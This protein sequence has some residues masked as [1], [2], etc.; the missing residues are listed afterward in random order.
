MA[1]DARTDGDESGGRSSVWTWLL[2]AL[3]FVA[4]VALG[5][6]VVAVGASGGDD[7][8]PDVSA[9]PTSE[10]DAGA[11][12]TSTAPSDA[13]VR[14][15]AACLQAADAAEEA[16][17]QVD[18]LVEAVRVFDAGR[19]QEL[20]DRFQELQPEVQR[21]ADACRE[22]AGDRLQDGDLVTPTPAPAPS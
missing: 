12:P 16:A 11:E 17:R 9:S 5:A 1:D 3:A 8:Q 6:V 4:G 7:R 13:V 22:V 18:D 21:L 15:P 19:L 14:V 10:P 20:V 2:P